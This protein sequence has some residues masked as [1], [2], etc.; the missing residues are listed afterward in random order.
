MV[1]LKGGG[2]MRE[3]GGCEGGEL[4]FR[5]FACNLTLTRNAQS[6]KIAILGCPQK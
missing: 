3:G 2:G 4:G 6:L 1:G 5:I